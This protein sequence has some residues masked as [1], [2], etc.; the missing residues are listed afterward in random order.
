[1]DI[2]HRYDLERLEWQQFEILSFK[3]LQ[4][5]IS[6]SLYFIEG[7]SDKGRDFVY[8][9]KTDFF[10]DG[11]QEHK[12]L[13][14]AKHKTSHNSFSSLNKD[15]KVELEKVFIKNKF[16]YDYYCLVT[17]IS[18]SGSHLDILDETFNSFISENNLSHEIQF[19]IYSYRQIESCLDNND[20]L[21][22]IFPSII[23][24][25]DFKLLM[26]DIVQKD[27]KNISS[28]W[29][30]VFEKNRNNF[31]YTN[32]FNE[33][34]SKLALNNI[35]LL[36]GPSK[37]GKTFNA[38]ML[39]F[40]YF[41]AKSFTPY[42]IDRIEEFDRFYDSTQSQIFLFDDA[43]GKYNIDLSRADSFNRKLE[44]IFELIDDSHKCIFTSREYIYK[45]F[46]NY[47]EDEVK[48]FITKITV[49]VDNLTKGEKESIFLRY[50][51]LL[52]DKISL[53][54]EN[55]SFILNHKN[56]SPETIR[57][58]FVNNNVFDLKSFIKHLDSPDDY[59]E[60]DFVNLSEEKK[61]V[62]ISALL[63]LKGT[64]SSISYSY[65]KICSDLNKNSLISINDVLYQLDGSMLKRSDEEYIFYHP[66][67]FEFFVRYISKDTSIYKKLL[68][69]NINIRLLEI[70]R[71]N[72]NIQLNPNS[73]EDAIKIGESDL[74]L[75]IEGF[76]R[77]LNNPD[78]SIVE[79]N[80]IISWITNTDVQLGLKIKLKNK[81]IE[82]KQKITLL[83]IDFD[84]SK[85]THE[86]TYQL[87]SFFNIIHSN[88]SEIKI[89]DKFI[90]KLIEV[91]K[92]SND[93]WF[94]VFR[95]I[96]LLDDEF[97]FKKITRE[98]L[99]GFFIELRNEINSLG[100]ELYGEAYPEFKEL[101]EYN[102][103]KKVKQKEGQSMEMKN[104]ATFKKNT[105]RNWYP[106]YA[107]VKEKMNSLKTCH[108]HGHKIYN[109]LISH[110]SHLKALEHNQ[111]NRYIF[112]KE[113]KW[114]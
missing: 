55:L 99:N 49:E 59:L 56:F 78:L 29:L 71:F 85:I 74:N 10:G 66:S 41:S 67:M 91:H 63:S 36:S 27:G 75:L 111:F 12:Y 83:L 50:Y 58:Y 79:L 44:Y 54:E 94:L 11:N 3:C 46:L 13:F 15:L 28:G 80:S 60:K 101:E 17:N 113:K 95:M 103:L 23:R 22:W 16:D 77:V 98:W 18:I 90:E 92:E 93:Y 48:T 65:D 26:E 102:K 61:I 89:E 52:S 62:L 31:V 5:D 88:Y 25:A 21:K 9:G 51:K 108:P 104:R 34:F 87:G 37:S 97:I 6:K 35:L 114:W 112:N 33:A 2:K 8:N 81:Y 24:N 110:F 4:L 64:V 53:Q 70:I 107:K 39:L 105:S 109:L 68:L 32:I 73:G 19:R 96:N 7:G 38:E 69:L 30:S 42:K 47:S 45:A 82:F 20:S 72:P 76:K 106:R 84:Y 14:Q 86:D 100:K 43:F 57:A 1:M 40:S